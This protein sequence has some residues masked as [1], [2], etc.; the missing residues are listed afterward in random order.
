M[1]I[2]NR[3]KI[4][5]ELTDLLMQFDKDMNSYQTDVYMYINE[6]SNTASLDTFVNVGGNSWLNDDHYTIY[7]DKEHYDGI[8]AFY[9]ES[10]EYADAIGIDYGVLKE[11]ARAYHEYDDIDDVDYTDIEKYVLSR[12]DYSEKVFQAYYDYI[13]ESRSEY[14]ERAEKIISHY[15]DD[16]GNIIE[17]EEY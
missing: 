16:D 12:D 7:T 13:D 4:V 9:S 14:V 3:E 1:K 2:T 5:E 11:E 8:S 6:E 10:F 17:E 15:I